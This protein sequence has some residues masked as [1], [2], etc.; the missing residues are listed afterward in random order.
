[1][2]RIRTMMSAL[3]LLVAGSV[4]LVAPA[5]ASAAEAPRSSTGQRWA[6]QITNGVTGQDYY[7]AAELSAELDT[8]QKG[9]L[10]AMTPA[11]SPSAI[12]SRETFT[13]HTADNGATVSLRNED[14]GLYV[15]T[16]KN[17]ATPY[18]TML[19]ARAASI[20][21]SST[22]Y[23][24]F[25]L[26]KDPQVAGAYNL[27]ARANQQ[28]VSARFSRAV[29]E[30]PGMLLAATEAATGSW[31]R[32]RLVEVPGTGQY[33][34]T[35]NP[36]ATA[37]SPAGTVRNV[38]SWNACSNH[39]ADCLLSDATVATVGNTVAARAAAA[40]ADV[41]FV[42]EFCEKSAVPLESSLEDRAVG[43]LAD[44]DVRFTP[45]YRK[46][47]GTGVLAQKQCAN[48]NGADRGAYGTAVAVPS[49]NTWYRSVV[50]PSRDTAEQR[51]ML[52]ATVPS[53]GTAYCG[54]HFSAGLTGDDVEEKPANPHPTGYFRN[55]QAQ[56]AFAEA[57]T[58]RA[59]GYEV[60]F[61]GDLN[62]TPPD[63]PQGPGS[64]P[65]SVLAPLYHQ[66]GAADDR[67]EECDQQ[68]HG[69]S[70]TGAPTHVSPSSSLKLDYVF[71]PQS[72]D[73]ACSITT[74]T[75]SDHYLIRAAVSFH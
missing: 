14:N 48:S 19:R 32:V 3:T 58:L 34:D 4:G 72:A 10:R 62:A 49:E 57:S 70:R 26:V 17:Y 67:F 53:Q 43:G 40:D 24:K 56:R 18:T 29:G 64:A 50:L 74:T 13:L 2:K 28:Y 31:E 23:E 15:S 33:G 46:L 51:P 54:G 6:L 16:E 7:V 35:A 63:A 68:A 36:P 71:G 30:G 52:C 38:V 65:A 55:L 41:M 66:P 27:K 21:T 9:R 11:S 20:G 45:T 60:V 39:N 22:A 1:M 12:G 69:G 59:Q 61:G 25:Q 42:Q 8:T 44:W 75:Q 37:N 73:Y 5:P 47:T